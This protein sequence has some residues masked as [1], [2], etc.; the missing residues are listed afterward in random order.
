[1][2]I[3]FVLFR[4]RGLVGEHWVVTRIALA[5]LVFVYLIASAKGDWG[6]DMERSWVLW[7]LVYMHSLLRGG[8]HAEERQSWTIVCKGCAVLGLLR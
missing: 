4:D 5:S 8:G 1:M 3:D 2:R 7:A 6:P